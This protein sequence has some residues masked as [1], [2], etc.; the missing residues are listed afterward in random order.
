[1]CG[2]VNF[3]KAQILQ[4][5]NLRIMIENDSVTSTITTYRDLKLKINF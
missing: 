5:E 2:E 4:N 1:M 3:N